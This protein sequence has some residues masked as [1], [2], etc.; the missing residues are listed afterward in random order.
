MPDAIEVLKMEIAELERII[1]DAQAKLAPKRQALLILE[2]R[3]MPARRRLQP[4]P[5]EAE[6]L[7]T[8]VQ[9][10]RAALE[11]HGTYLTPKAIHDAIEQLFHKDVATGTL[12]SVLYVG[13]AN[14][15]N[16]CRGPER[17]EYGLIEWEG[18]DRPAKGG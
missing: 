14:K 15:V 5:V 17:G 3:M 12:A 7:K 8:T 9:F 10:A 16:F 11:R 18:T 13:A 1:A 6:P 4:I 2:P